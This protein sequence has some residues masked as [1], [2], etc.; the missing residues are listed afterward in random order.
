MYTVDGYGMNK[1]GF[2]FVMHEDCQVEGIVS[3]C[4]GNGGGDI[5]TMRLLSNQ[6]R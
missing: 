6:Y 1:L 5:K 4:A 2:Q 3:V